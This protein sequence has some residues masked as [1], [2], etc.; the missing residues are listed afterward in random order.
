MTALVWCPFPD[1]ASARHVADT[2]LQERLIACANLLDGVQ[3]L[4]LWN[5]EAGQADECGALFKTGAEL[6]ESAVQ[7]IAQLHPYETPAVMG[8]RCDAVPQIT[9]DWIE[10]S[11]GPVTA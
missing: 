2:L 8:W 5:G 11:T 10:A 1:N 6:L 3:S 9:R 7:R 4:F